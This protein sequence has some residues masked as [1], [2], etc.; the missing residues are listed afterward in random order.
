MG[1]YSIFDLDFDHSSA[2]MILIAAPWE[3]S[4]SYRRGSSNSPDHIVKTSSQIDAFY[5][6]YPQLVQKGICYLGDIA[7]LQDQQGPLLEISREYIQNFENKTNLSRK[8]KFHL[9]ALNH[10]CIRMIGDLKAHILN[11]ISQNKHVGMIGGEHS[12]SEAAIQALSEKFSSFSILQIDAHMD[13]RPSYQQLEHSHASVMYNCLKVPQ[14][15]SLC[16]VSCRDFS[17]EEFS[18]CRQ[19]KSRINSFTAEHLAQNHFEGK[20]W[21][22]Q[23]NE[24][25]SCL[26]DD[27][28]VTVDIDGLCPAFCPQT[29]TPVPGGVSYHQLIYLLKS[30]VRSKKRMIG[31]D[32]VEVV[33]STDSLDCIV[34]SHL[35]FQLSMLC[36]HSNER[37]S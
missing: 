25:I 13:L 15:S 21:Q 26:S 37:S 12:V 4:A 24:I 8:S 35:L 1:K 19:N 32:L 7:K 3:L 30:L 17:Q 14:V 10:A 27:V 16:Q 33:G 31:F 18:F 6:G 36:L 2:E 23:C 22:S 5:P 11:L 9:K 28:Y 20:S 29:G 34:A